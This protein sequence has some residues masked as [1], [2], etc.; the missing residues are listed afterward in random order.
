MSQHLHSTAAPTRIPVYIYIYIMSMAASLLIPGKIWS[1]TIP[2]ENQVPDN[3]SHS[4]YHHTFSYYHAEEEKAYKNFSPGLNYMTSPI[5]ADATN[6][7]KGSGKVRIIEIKKSNFN[8]NKNSFSKKPSQSNGYFR[9]IANGD[10]HEANTW[11][12]SIDKLTWEQ[13]NVV[14]DFNSEEILIRQQHKIVIKQSLTLD[15]VVVEG[16]LQY[17]DFSGSLI[18]M[19][20]GPGV[21]LR[22]L[23]IYEDF[24]PHSNDWLSASTWEM[25]SGGSLI[26]S[27]STS[28][29]NWRDHYQGGIDQIPPSSS[30]ILRKSGGDNPSAHLNEAMHY[31]NL[32]IENFT[33]NKWETEQASPS[34]SNSV[35]IEHLHIGG[36]GTGDVSFVNENPQENPVLIRGDLMV[37]ENS[38]LKNHGAGL[39]VQGNIILNGKIDFGDSEEKIILSGQEHQTISSNATLRLRNLEI[40]KGSASAGVELHAPLEITKKLTLTR[41]HIITTEANILALEKN[42]VVVGGSEEAFIKGPMKKTGNTEFT[43]P[44]GKEGHFQPIKISA[45]SDSNAIFKAEYFRGDHGLGNE[46]EPNIDNISNCEHWNLERI[47]GEDAVFVS[48]GWNGGSCNVADNPEDMRL[49]KWNGVKWIE[50]GFPLA[51]LE[52]ARSLIALT[53]FGKFTIGQKTIF[54]QNPCGTDL[55]MNIQRSVNPD[56]D[57]LLQIQDEEIQ[58]K[59]EEIAQRE[60]G[61]RALQCNPKNYVIPVVVHVI[62]PEVSD[63]NYAKINIS[64]DQIQSQ[65]R[66]LNDAF[67][68]NY[69]NPGEF[70]TNT[71]IKFCLAKE[72]GDPYVNWAISGEPGVMRYQ[73]PN[74]TRHHMNNNEAEALF[75]LTHPFGSTAFANSKYL[76]I[77]VVHYINEGTP[78]SEC[79]NIQ[80]YAPIPILGSFP[81][82]GIVI[83]SD[84]FGDNSYGEN[85]FLQPEKINSLCYTEPRTQGKTLVHEVGH[86]LNLYHTFHPGE[87]YGCFGALDANCKT[88]GDKVCDTPP[89]WRKF[90]PTLECLS[91]LNENSCTNDNIG[92]LGDR[93][94]QIENYMNYSFD[95]CWNTFTAEQTLRMKAFLEIGRQELFS[96]QNLS[97]L[98]IIASG[99]CVEPFPSA[100]FTISSTQACIG[101]ETT[102]SAALGNGINSINWDWNF[103]DG[104]I[105]SGST[106]AHIYTEPGI[107]LVTLTVTDPSGFVISSCETELNV[108][109]CEL[110]CSSQPYWYFGNKLALDFSKGFPE[111]ITGSSLSSNYEATVVQHDKNGNLLFY[112]NGVELY[113]ANGA[114]ITTLLGYQSNSQVLSVPSPLHDDAYFLFYRKTIGP[115]YT[116]TEQIGSD[117]LYSIVRKSGNSVIVNSS[118]K[119]IKVFNTGNHNFGEQLS[120]V[121]HPNGR[122][123][124]II[125]VSAPNISNRLFHVY[126]LSCTG[127]SYS[128]GY[129]NPYIGIHGLLKVSPDFTKIAISGQIIG[130]NPNIVIADFN[131]LTGQITSPTILSTKPAYGIEF[132]P[133]SKLLYASEDI[134]LSAYPLTYLVQYNLTSPP[135]KKYL[136]TELATTAKGM[137]L[138]PDNKIYISRHGTKYLSVINLPNNMEDESTTAFECDLV[139]E[140]VIFSTASCQFGLPNMMICPNPEKKDPDF[141][142]NSTSCFNKQFIVENIWPQYSFKWDFGDGTIIGPGAPT[143]IISGSNTTGTFSNPHHTYSAYGTYQVTLTISKSTCTLPPIT[144]NIDIPNL[145]NF[146]VGDPLTCVGVSYTYYAPFN[147]NYLYNWSIVGGTINSI[148]TENPSNVEVNWVEGEGTI[149]LEISNGGCTFNS[150]FEV[151]ANSAPIVNAGLDQDLCTDSESSIGGDPV[152]MGNGPFTYF[153]SPQ[154]YL[155]STSTIANPQIKPIESI[156]YIVEVT[157]VNGCKNF[158]EVDIN[159]ITET[160]QANFTLDPTLACIGNPILFQFT[161][162]AP[163]GSTFLWDFRDG[164]S[165]EENPI[166]S[167]SISGTVIVKL[168]VT[169]ICGSVSVFKAVSVLP[170][171]CALN[172]VYDIDKIIVNP[173]TGNNVNWTTGL[174]YGSG[175]VM[176]VSGTITVESGTLYLGY[177]TIKF[178]PNGKIIVKPGAKLYLDDDLDLTSM[179]GTCDLMWQGIEVWGNNTLPQSPENQGTIT[180]FQ[181]NDIM[182][183]H[184]GILFGKPAPPFSPSQP[185]DLSKSGG[186]LDNPGG[187]TRFINCGIG[188]KIISYPFPNNNSTTFRYITQGQLLDPNYNSTTTPLTN[189]YPNAFNKI[190]GNSNPTGRGYAGVYLWN[191]DLVKPMSGQYENIEYCISGVDA[192]FNVSSAIFKNFT[193]GINIKN[194]AS[195]IFYQHRIFN[196]LFRDFYKFSNNGVCINIEGGKSD[197]IYSNI[198]NF[199]PVSPPITTQSFSGVILTNSSGFNIYGNTFNKLRFGI[200]ADKSGLAGGNIAPHT[201]NVFDQCLYGVLTKNY[202]IKLQLRCNTHNNTSLNSAFFKKNWIVYQTLGNQ[203]MGPVLPGEKTEHTRPAGNKFHPLNQFGEKREI[204]A[205]NKA[206]TYYRH[207]TAFIGNPN[208]VEPV[209]PLGSQ[210]VSVFNTGTPEQA[211]SCAPPGLCGSGCKVIIIGDQAEEILEL[212]NE[213]ASLLSSL[214]KGETTTLLEAINSTMSDGPLRTKL[215]NA[216]PLS[217]AVL[218]PFINRVQATAPGVFKDVIITNSPVSNSVMP[219][220][221]AKL[222]NLPS[223]IAKLI[224]EA[225]GENIGFRTSTVIERQIEYTEQQRQLN[226]NDAVNSFVEENNIG[227]AIELLEAENTEV[228]AGLLAPYYLADNE[229]AKA[230]TKF[231]LLP[232]ILPED[233]QYLELND[234]LLDLGLNGNTVFDLT[235]EQEQSLRIIAESE[236]SSL[237]RSNAR[238]IFY[239][240]YGEEFPL[241]MPAD[242]EDVDRSF[243]EEPSSETTDSIFNSN[244]LDLKEFKNEYSSYLG[245][246]FPNPVSSNSLI[247]YYLQ[248]NHFGIIKIFD[249]QGN[250]VEKYPL[251]SGKNTLQINCRNLENGIYMYQMEIDGQ[252]LDFKRMVIIR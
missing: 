102:F 112:S 66:A 81:L 177:N 36:N 219:V 147:E 186:I 249:M 49:V 137:Q 115:V 185:Y 132:S 111:Q 252:I 206:F 157:D 33:G 10:W 97:N 75:N 227:G 234:I 107:V 237:A 179:G 133:D 134:S 93:N 238:S 103:G 1:Q 235:T 162:V 220:L 154:T 32:F 199:E 232:G 86:Y 144:K 222:I 172:S 245:S 116:T 135:T 143:A 37:K 240:L 139:L 92:G 181:G 233:Q 244:S 203:G 29:Q 54:L 195:S 208:S 5:L 192:K 38:T 59:M 131:N 226:F 94:D 6:V 8:L 170:N 142:V 34:N 184:I 4:A 193:Y 217:D 22:I 70:S 160:P 124:W 101:K 109:P 106:I 156:S 159:V 125:A 120:V 182:N 198:F 216:S 197:I 27:R 151:T 209:I 9:T 57:E 113:D 19:N 121:P 204:N 23:G 145:T 42:A 202:N 176:T 168:T 46:K 175:N 14:P 213:L 136:G 64:Y 91:A 210:T 178:G 230:E 164:I 110:A 129:S 242:L 119:N 163:E 250:L 13:A 87:M 117:L 16:V 62:N 71:G 20:D 45:P 140:G 224:R 161:G 243:L 28:T 80:G 194:T 3:I 78:I 100:E 228:S 205:V 150:D 174:P 231:A 165:T 251:N 24:G 89:M 41:G 130:N 30:W 65:I 211:T 12:A 77:Y 15:Q 225:Q 60:S 218:I 114:L 108:T 21:D 180:L 95:E 55:V 68:N 56:F 61:D 196:N 83:R 11:E 26:R 189:Q 74:L 158:D 214:D 98:G 48:L 105:G 72:T 171:C 31:P 18:T 40:N 63:Q 138:G 122:D 223:G 141:I 104:K 239:L 2:A 215:L 85:Y 221:D 236:I 58:K 166:H 47:N 183:A 90:G 152:A 118:E 212:K 247:S 127:L 149:S 69:L 155:T 82:D 84:L 39:E 53:S 123:Y 248:I 43:F 7:V 200:R 153:W 76:N 191:V 35:I 167:F 241:D 88:E 96:H 146:I 126:Y 99:G 17:G 201:G 246:N 229:Y 188:I 67:N 190:Y 187:D 73:D 25:G 148:L 128:G 169:N 173:G 207:K 52:K 79:P 51:D 50:I 44:V